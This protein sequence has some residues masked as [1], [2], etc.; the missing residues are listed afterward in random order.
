M[1]MQVLIRILIIFLIILLIASCGYMFFMV[2]GAKK[3]TF[4]L[5]TQNIV[6]TEEKIRLLEQLDKER[7]TQ[8]KKEAMIEVLEAELAELEDAKSIKELL[9]LS[10]QKLRSLSLEFDKMEQDNSLLK[11]TNL[12]LSSRLRNLTNEFTKTLEN[13][14]DVKKELSEVKS[15]KTIRSYINRIEKTERI[16]KEREADILEL[17]QRID[18]VLKEKKD[19]AKEKKEFEKRITKLEKERRRLERQVK[20]TKQKFDKKYGPNSK[21]ERRLKE[22]SKLV[23]DKEKH[24]KQLNDQIV[25][26]REDKIRLDEKV[27]MQQRKIAELEENLTEIKNQEKKIKELEKEK[28]EIQKDLEKANEQLTKKEKVIASLEK[29]G[30]KKSKLEIG[31][32][33]DLVEGKDSEQFQGDLNKAYALYDTAKAQMV[34]FSELLMNKELE[35]ETS[36]QKIKNLEKELQQFKQHPDSG[37]IISVDR[38]GLFQD[39]IRILNKALIDKEE[40]L[41]KKEEEL[42]ALQMSKAALEE[43]LQYQKEEFKNANTLYA[44]LKNRLVKTTELLTRKDSDLLEKNKEILNFKSELALLQ[45]ENRVLEQEIKDLQQRYR[46]VIEELTRATK[47]NVTLQENLLGDSKDSS[48]RQS[49]KNRAEQL[50]KEVEMLLGK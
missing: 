4:G 36:K 9:S 18:H 45:A 23:N 39:R 1:I 6:L 29:A 8:E 38:A 12:T 43:R 32:I 41:Q 16:L 42:A 30:L 22:L 13:L 50:K 15:D 14:K 44:D 48:F 11:Q 28:E 25:R 46:G 47:L 5:K 49:S 10:Q 37:G 24:R 19:W 35:L 27:N 7:E 33:P 20:D 31:E 34:K 17:Q 40:R 26:L 21:L 2:T 3:E